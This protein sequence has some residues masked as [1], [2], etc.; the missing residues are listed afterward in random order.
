MGSTTN[1]EAIERW[2]RYIIPAVFKA[3][4]QLLEEHPEWKDRLRCLANG[5]EDQH[6]VSAEYCNT[7]ATVIVT[8]AGGAVTKMKRMNEQ[9]K[10]GPVCLP[11]TSDD[12]SYPYREC[13]P[14]LRIYT[15]SVLHNVSTED[16]RLSVFLSQNSIHAPHLL[17]ALASRYCPPTG[18]LHL[19]LDATKKAQSTGQWALS[20][21]FG[22]DETATGI[23]PRG[24]QRT[25]E[26]CIANINICVCAIIQTRPV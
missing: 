20:F 2:A 25:L 19:T 3:E 13:L 14:F 8:A 12:E 17:S 15:D 7:I 16:E 4:A 5:E 1:K 23:L 9:K 18:L 22:K 24:V 6:K 10:G 21:P 11:K 26:F